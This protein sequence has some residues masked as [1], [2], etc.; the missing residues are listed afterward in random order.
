MEL[1]EAWPPI[2]LY[3]WC[4]PQWSKSLLPGSLYQFMGYIWTLFKSSQL[5]EDLKR[6]THINFT[7]R[8]LQLILH[9][10]N[11]H[12]HVVYYK[13]TVSK[14]ARCWCKNRQVN[15]WNRSENAET[16]TPLYSQPN[17]VKGS[18]SIYWGKD[19]LSINTAGKSGYWHAGDKIIPSPLILCQNQLKIDWK[20]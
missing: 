4:F 20:P 12:W 7:T 11:S 9:I 5:T 10:S 15:Q 2:Y 3:S 19:S 1:M 16:L 6:T 14:A 13:A 17:F 18:N 8:V